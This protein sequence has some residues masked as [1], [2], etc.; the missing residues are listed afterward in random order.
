MARGVQ[1]GV[2]LDCQHPK[3][4]PAINPHS[5]QYLFERLWIAPGGWAGCLWLASHLI[6]SESRQAIYFEQILRL[7]GCLAHAIGVLKLA[8][9]PIPQR[10]YNCMHHLRH[11]ASNRLYH[12]LFY[13]ILAHRDRRG[14]ICTTFCALTSR[15]TAFH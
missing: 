13:T 10:R 15:I 8:A 14:V 5:G 12:L 4:S 7:G 3:R 11:E 9:R 1:G 6:P 2:V